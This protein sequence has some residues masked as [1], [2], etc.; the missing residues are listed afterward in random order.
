MSDSESS[1]PGGLAFT[2]GEQ[3][4]LHLRLDPGEMVAG[5]IQRQ[6][7]SDTFTFQGWLDLMAVISDLRTRAPL[8]EQAAKP[9]L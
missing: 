6:G 7:D 8:T 4:V 5:S 9:E 2:A 1:S 3:F